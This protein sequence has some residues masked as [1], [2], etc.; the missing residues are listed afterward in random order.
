MSVLIGDFTDCSVFLY[1][2]NGNHLGSTTIIE[3]DRRARQ[4]EVDLIPP[5]LKVND[6]CKV[7]ILTSPIPCEF[8]G[9]LKKVGGDLLIALFQGQ[10]K[11]NR[12]ATRY[13][14]NTPAKIDALITDNQPNLLQAP[15]G[16]ILINISTSGVRFRAPYFSLVEG[17]IFRINLVISNSSK[18]MIAEVINSVDNGTKS[19]DYGCR[20]VEV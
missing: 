4:I 19:S 13:K 6:T 2:T 11:E 3:H 12:A 10:E 16:V 7:F 1:D 17:D 18:T 14:V 8:S 20:F 9:N 15:L 5:E